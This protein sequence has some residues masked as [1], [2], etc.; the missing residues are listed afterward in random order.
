MPEKE[1]KEVEEEE[2]DDE[3]SDQGD[4]THLENPYAHRYNPPIQCSLT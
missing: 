3:L 2:D 4:K 1:E